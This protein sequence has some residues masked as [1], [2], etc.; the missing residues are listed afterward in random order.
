M[1]WQGHRCTGAPGEA[2]A[3]VDPGRGKSLQARRLFGNGWP[4]LAIACTLL[5]MFLRSSLI[6]L[7][8]ARRELRL[9]GGG[10]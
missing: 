3:R 9:S 7:G 5:V 6:V 10:E 8:H 4:D 2:E 1:S